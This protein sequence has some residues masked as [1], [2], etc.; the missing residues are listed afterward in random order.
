[1]KRSGFPDSLI[2]AGY[3]AKRVARKPDGLDWDV[4][5]VYSL[6]GCCISKDFTDYVYFWKHNGYWLFD[7]PEKIEEVA[8]EDAVDL[9]GTTLFY[10]EIYGHQFDG[11]DRKW[12]SFE[13]EPFGVNILIPAEKRLEGFDV[14][15][16][17]AGGTPEHSPLSCNNLAKSIHTNE[18]CLLESLEQAIE[19]LEAGSFA[20]SEPGP[21]RIFAVYTLP[22]L[23]LD[24]SH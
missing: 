14:L 1:M 21:Y 19:E 20:N 7:S 2:P 10:Y 8:R 5:D 3:L 12:K 16:F 6:S 13:P 9:A 22:S 18:H 4:V 11:D 23:T 24:A 15:T 17:F